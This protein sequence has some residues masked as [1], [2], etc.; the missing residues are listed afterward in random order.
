M[1]REA[2]RAAAM[3]SQRVRYDQV[4]ELN[5]RNYSKSFNLSL[6]S[7]LTEKVGIIMGPSYGIVKR[8]N[9]ANWCKL[10][11][12]CLSWSKWSINAVYLFKGWSGRQWLPAELHWCFLK[13]IWQ[14]ACVPWADSSEGGER[15]FGGVL[16]QEMG[17]WHLLSPNH[18]ARAASPS[19][20]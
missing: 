19:F 8:I 10:V 15:K 6:L 11:E 17:N 2:W 9:W 3:G 4:S 1:D 13:S 7:L 12:Q 5:W 16:E 20:Y 14:W 18:V